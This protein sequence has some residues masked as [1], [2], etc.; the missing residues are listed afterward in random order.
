MSAL[1][2]ARTRTVTHHPARPG[3]RKAAV[4]D[5][6]RRVQ[7]TMAVQGLIHRGE[8]VLVGVSGGA[9]SVTLLH[10][11][12]SW[13]DQLALSLCAVHVDH[14]LRPE[15]ARDATWVRQFAEG[16]NVPIMVECCDVRSLCRERGWSLE[17]GARRVRYQCFAASAVQY[18]AHVL[19]L[20]HTADDQAETVLMRLLRGSGLAG[21]SGIPI[22][23]S[24]E[25]V[26]VVRPLLPVWRW[27]ILEYLASQGLSHREDAS[28]L[29]VRFTRNRIRHQLLPL[30]E[31]D[32]NPQAKSVFVQLAEQCRDD[33]AYLEQLAGRHWKR[34]AKISPAG[35]V[36][37][38]MR[39]LARQAVSLQRYLVRRAV[40]QVRGELTEFEFRH[41]REIDALL[42]GGPVGAEAHLPGGVRVSRAAEHLVFKRVQES[43]ASF[44]AE[45]PLEAPSETFQGA[46]AA[47]RLR[48]ALAH[49]S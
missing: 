5:L 46:S 37:L 27:E 31:R 28:N 19:A 24:L 18:S 33:S 36:S 29:D 3:Q 45:Q 25:H 16:L 32:Y 48:P 8:R 13:R 11:L 39:P 23:R 30:L 26:R 2:I 34:L 22:V 6:A 4:E 21:L 12:A 1:R 7:R 9:D 17:D 41:W 14:Q 43:P 44:L 20:A 49:H 15:S 42:Q 35:E 10:M 47:R 40:R 38:A